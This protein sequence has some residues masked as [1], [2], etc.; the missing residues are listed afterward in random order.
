MPDWIS[1]VVTFS[2]PFDTPT[3]TVRI[4][5]P[6]YNDT[7]QQ[8]TAPQFKLSMDG[9]VYSYLKGSKITLLLSFKN[10]TTTLL[11][12]FQTFYL[13]SIGH[14]VRYLDQNNANWKGRIMDATLNINITGADMGGMTIQFQG[15]LDD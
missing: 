12:D 5:K 4:N 7:L 11:T 13:A 6:E 14:E 8:S 3:V 9:D 10:I 1:G 15:E 2:Y